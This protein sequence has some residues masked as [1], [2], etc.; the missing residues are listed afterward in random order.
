MHVGMCLLRL[1]PKT[2][3]A[4][5]PVEFFAMAGG[6]TDQNAAPGRDSLEALMKAFSDG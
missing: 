4:L 2:F 5:T 1:P 6:L 3:W